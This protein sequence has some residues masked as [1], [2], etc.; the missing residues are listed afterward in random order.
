[1]KIGYLNN[2]MEGNTLIYD[3]ISCDIPS[4][5]SRIGTKING[6]SHLNDCET[7]LACRGPEYNRK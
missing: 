3:N 7:H 1:M 5:L 6:I 2:R 4:L